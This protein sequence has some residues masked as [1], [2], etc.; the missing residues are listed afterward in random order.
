MFFNKYFAL[1]FI[2]AGCLLILATVACSGPSYKNPHVEI[3]T[4]FGNIELELYPDKAPASV[5]A[6]LSYIDSGY[7]KNTSFYRVLNVDNQPSDA[8]KAELIQGG[9]FRSAGKKNI[10]PPGIPHESTDKTGLEHK[11][12]A[13]SLARFK[14]GSANTEFFICVGDQPGF[15]FGGENNPDGQGY[16]AF[17]YIVDGLDVVR[18]IYNQR[19]DEQYFD[20][21]VIIYDVVKL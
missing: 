20:P 17:G 8:P 21:P 5:A 14:P 6:F 2:V 16:A 18:K 13:I 11:N 15:N 3:R 12:G 10:N 1:P 4:K 9:L 7:F 19:E